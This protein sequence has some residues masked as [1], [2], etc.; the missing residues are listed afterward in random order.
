MR[1]TVVEALV[2][3]LDAFLEARL[4][5]TESHKDSGDA[6][7][8]LPR[9]GG[10]AY[11]NGE[12]RLMTFL[13]A[14][15]IDAQ[16]LD[17]EKI[18]DMALDHFRMESGTIQDPSSSDPGCFVLDS[19]AI[20][21]IE[22]QVEKSAFDPQASDDEWEQAKKEAGAFFK[23]NLGY[24]SSDRVWYALIDSKTL[25]REVERASEPEPEID[26]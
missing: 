1:E 8:H 15:G 23:G 19:Y 22:V 10:F 6:Y 2:E 9:E 16:G 13:A 11:G 21:E 12:T 18:S 4:E 14:Q 5:W 24:L 7:S 25:R 26:F 17:P 3:K 20:G